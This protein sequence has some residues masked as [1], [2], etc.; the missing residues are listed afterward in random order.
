LIQ[1]AIDAAGDGDSIRIRKGVFVENVTISHK[2]L[3]LQGAGPLAAV[4]DGGGTGRA[5]D[6]AGDFGVARVGPA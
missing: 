4:L 2:S 5:V 1:A 3:T 6:I